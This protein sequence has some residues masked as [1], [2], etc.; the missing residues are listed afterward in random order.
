MNLELLKKLREVSQASLNECRK[1]LE[2]AQNDFNKALEILKKKGQLIAEKKSERETKAGLI[3]A[4]VHSNG[5]VGA[6]VELRCETDFVAK[7]PLFKELAHD[8]ALQIAAM[9]P[10]Y[11]SEADIPEEV[12]KE[13]KEIYREEL[14]STGK[15]EKIIEQ[16][17]EGKLKKRFSEICLLN[18]PFIKNPD[19]TIESVIKSYIAKLGENIKVERFAR[20]EL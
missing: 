10:A 6:L 1:A 9:A 3:E 2:E 5:R 4:Y 16:I 7:N 17:I 8:L 11:V 19:E 18:Q 15:P 13:E 20:F 12:L 14:K